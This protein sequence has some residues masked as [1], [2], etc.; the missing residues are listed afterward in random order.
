MESDSDNYVGFAMYCAEVAQRGFWD[1]HGYTTNSHIRI[2]SIDTE[3][4]GVE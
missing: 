4:L 1:T 3:V 2:L